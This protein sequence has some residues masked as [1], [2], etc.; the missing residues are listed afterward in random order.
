MVQSSVLILWLFSIFLIV[1]WAESND[2]TGISTT[3]RI[4]SRKRRYLVFP[5]GSS[6]S[7]AVCMTVG[8][9]GNPSDQFL[10]WALNW[11]V[12]YDLPNNVTIFTGVGRDPEMAVLPEEPVPAAQ[13]RFRRDLYNR[14][15]I[16]IDSMGHNGKECVKRALCESKQ[17]FKARGG[18]MIEEMIRTLFSLPKTRVF[19]F[20]N[21]AIVPYDKAHRS[22]RSLKTDCT[23]LYKECSFSLID[24]AL[25]R[26]SKPPPNYQFM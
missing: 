16:I 9:I 18:N 3:E 24:V 6:F 11:G 1:V 20:E 17:M 10:S 7:C 15:E 8:V 2:S 13:R 19:S 23:K 5:E 4:L 21:Q 12:A 14:L 25:G 26:H 22:G